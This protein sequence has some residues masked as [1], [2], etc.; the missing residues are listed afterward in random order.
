MKNLKEI[1]VSN[2]ASKAEFSNAGIGEIVVAN[3]SAAGFAVPVEF[4]QAL[5]SFASALAGNMN[6]VELQRF[7][8]PHVRVPQHFEYAVS[9]RLD[10]FR[11]PRL[12][13]MNR[14][15]GGE[16]P[17]VGSVA[18][19]EKASLQDFG[20]AVK[21][22]KKDY[23]DELARAWVERMKRMISDALLEGTIDM[24][25]AMAV[26]TTLSIASLGSTSLDRAIEAELDE[27]ST[28]GIRPNRILFGGQAWTTR[29]AWY[30]SKALAGSTI[31]YPRT[32]LDFT[33][34]MR[35][36][37]RIMDALTLTDVN[38]LSMLAGNT[39][40]AFFGQDAPSTE[41]P[42]NMKT[43]FGGEDSVYHGQNEQGTLHVLSVGTN[44]VLLPTCPKGVVKITLTD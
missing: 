34:D 39:I 14:P 20:L 31:P 21:I 25:D 15:R 18:T 16:Y 12:A 30:E 43:G 38:T 22:D 2:G 4:S 3:T 44:K 19:K 23:T 26:E 29:K 28:S 6:S 24:L 10:A 37:T 8:A 35:A 27:A 36:D 40:Y 17:L 11:R 42:S 41:D 5:T 9:D 32:S 33:Q 13:E 1:C 7:V